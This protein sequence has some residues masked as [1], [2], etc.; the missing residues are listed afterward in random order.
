M[1]V[2]LASTSAIRRALLE[3]AVLDFIVCPPETDEAALARDAGKVGPGRLA[4]ILANA[5]AVSVSNRSGTDFV[6]GADQV[7]SIDNLVLGKPASIDDATRQLRLLRR[8]EHL[9]QSAVCVAKDGIEQW[10]FVGTARLKM[11][12]FSDAFLKAYLENIGSDALTSVGGYKIEGLGIQLF[13]CIEGDY[14]TILGL[15]LLPLL[16]FLRRQGAIPS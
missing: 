4:Q 3:C 7:L 16:D 1:T 11:R 12:D 9:L 2:V 6:I 14:F 10:S 15:P 5:K 13:E 8:R